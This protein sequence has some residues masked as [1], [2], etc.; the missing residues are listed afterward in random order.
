MLPLE[1]ANPAKPPTNQEAKLDGVS[2]PLFPNLSQNL[3][4]IIPAQEALPDV[5]F[6]QFLKDRCTVQLVPI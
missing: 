5:I 1:I 3:V 4:E 2:S 6:F